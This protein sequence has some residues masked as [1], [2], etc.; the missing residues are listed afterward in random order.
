MLRIAPHF[1]TLPPKEHGWDRLFAAPSEQELPA[2]TQVRPTGDRP[3]SLQ[4]GIGNDCLRKG[5]TAGSG[6]EQLYALL[7][8][9]RSQNPTG[10]SKLR[11]RA[12]AAEL[13]PAFDQN[14][15]FRLALKPWSRSPSP[16]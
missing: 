3:T 16:N 7:Q 2:D 6:P 11:E 5:R 13:P 8:S 15:Q 12:G 9:G 10:E 14:V 1:Q 4:W